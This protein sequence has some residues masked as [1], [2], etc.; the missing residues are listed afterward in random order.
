VSSTAS[1]LLAGDITDLRTFA[2]DPRIRIQEAIPV[3]APL[4]TI[5][6]W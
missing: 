4:N 5:H 3:G 1:T 6:I 2:G